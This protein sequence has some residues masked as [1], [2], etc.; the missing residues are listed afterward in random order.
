MDCIAGT[1]DISWKAITW[2]NHKRQIARSTIAAKLQQTSCKKELHPLW[3]QIRLSLDKFKLFMKKEI[4]LGAIFSIV[5]IFSFFYT[6]FSKQGKISKYP[7]RMKIYFTRI[8]GLKQGAEVYVKGVET[9]FLYSIDIVDKSPIMDPRYLEP[10]QPKVV[11]LTL[12]MKQPVT[13]W[14]NYKIRFNTKTLFSDR[15][16]EIDPGFQPEGDE[17][18]YNPIFTERSPILPDF[19]P[20][21]VY[22]DNVFEGTNKV[23][24]EN[25]ND[26]RTI[27]LQTQGISEKLLGTDG[28][29]PLLINTSEMYDELDITLAMIGMTIRE[30]RRYQEGYRKMEQTFPIPLMIHLGFLNGTTLGGR[31][32]GGISSIQNAN[33][34]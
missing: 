5:L 7:Y 8:D 21:A 17:I 27:V 6:I 18:P 26:I 20:S 30:G 14:D 13:L 10:A 3:F 23:L 33:P 11:E 12:A 22:I 9:G 31:R 16:I 34:F 1:T 4:F 19:F 32:I 15:V 24:K 29:L 25:Q 28:T 2:R